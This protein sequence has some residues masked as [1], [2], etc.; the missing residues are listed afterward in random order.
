MTKTDLNGRELS[1]E[2]LDAIAAGGIFGD[3]W[4]GIEHAASAT[5]HWIEGPGL[6]IAGEIVKYIE[7]HPPTTSGTNYKAR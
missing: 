4:H 6:R 3:I 2:E 7:Q 1:T 5:W